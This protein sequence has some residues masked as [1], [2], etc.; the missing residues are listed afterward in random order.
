MSLDLAQ[1]ASSLFPPPGL[2]GAAVLAHDS[3]R[4][5]RRRE[6]YG[7]RGQRPCRFRTQQVACDCA[8]CR[9]SP[10]SAPRPVAPAPFGSNCSGVAQSLC[11]VAPSLCAVVNLACV[12]MWYLYLPDTMYYSLILR[13]CWSPFV[14]S[15]PKPRCWH[16]LCLLGHYRQQSDVH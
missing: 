9:E 16:S 1:V 15:W 8:V 2:S 12:F 5:R 11:T 10:L 6:R 4:R 3:W 7:Q 14:P 13:S